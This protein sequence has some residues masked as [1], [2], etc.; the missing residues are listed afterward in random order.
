[1]S[2]NTEMEVGVEDLPPSARVR[3]IA[4][5]SRIGTRTQKRA[6]ASGK[7]TKDKATKVGHWLKG[8][9]VNPYSALKMS[10]A[11]LMLITAIAG[12]FF[13]GFYVMLWAM[14]TMSSIWLSFLI[15]LAAGFIYNL[16]VVQPI[17]WFVSR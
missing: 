17:A 15:A 2:E 13:V 8:Q 1:M 4:L 11:T 3:T 7:F 14:A 16:I 5:M 9:V 12:A 10:A 6:I